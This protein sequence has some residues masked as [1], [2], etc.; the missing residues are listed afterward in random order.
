VWVTV[1]H[2]GVEDQLA[3]GEGRGGALRLTCHSNRPKAQQRRRRGVAPMA[4]VDPDLGRMGRER[5][6]VER[7]S[8]GRDGM[9]LPLAKLAVER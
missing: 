8:G 4:P 9:S 7:G 3:R 1:L 2:N 6:G 5:G